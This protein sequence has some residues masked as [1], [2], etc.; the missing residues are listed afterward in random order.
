MTA[1]MR[2]GALAKRAGISTDTLRFY[3]RRGLLAR[4]PRDANGYRRYPADALQRVTI[5]QRALDAGFTLE[6][7]GRILRQRD[8]GGAPCREVFAIASLRL[9]E[10][11]ER[12]AAL[13][14][15]RG[16]IGR[17]VAAW[18]RTLDRTPAGARA[19]LLETLATAPPASAALTRFRSSV[20]SR[21][22]G[23]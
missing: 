16:R 22:G 3:E 9:R 2:T 20:R 1:T 23:K 19:R 8:A 15:L 7:L 21:R 13:T 4:P 11:D 10:L 12:I 17:V 5:I 6:D 18:Q 14:E